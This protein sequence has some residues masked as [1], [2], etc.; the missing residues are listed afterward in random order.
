MKIK[1]VKK[2]KVILTFNF[3]TLKTTPLHPR[4]DAE[5][6]QIDDRQRLQC[7]HIQHNMVLPGK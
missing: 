7:G 3:K 4:R 6:S 1:N 5:K 2:L